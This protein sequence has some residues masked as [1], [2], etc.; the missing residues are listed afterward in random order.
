MS[1]LEALGA[2]NIFL[3]TSLVRAT[4][5][6]VSVHGALLAVVILALDAV[7]WLSVHITHSFVGSNLL[8]YI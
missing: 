2:L 5:E 1:Y 6:A 4:L 3:I 7:R 8:L